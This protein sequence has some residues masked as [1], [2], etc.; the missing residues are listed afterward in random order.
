MTT[1]HRKTQLTILAVTIVAAFATIHCSGSTTQP[2]SG[3]AMAGVAL[4]ASSIAA[5]T[6]M[7]GTV[8]LTSAAA[9][10]G[11]S[12]SLSSSN[13]AVATVQTPIMVPAGASSAT[14]TVTA[15]AAGTANFTASFNGT[16]QSPMLT[17]TGASAL[18]SL[19]LSAPTI[20]GGNPVV[21]TVTLSNPAPSGGAVVALS[22][23][24]PVTVP[25]TVTV[26][27]GSTSATF[28][29]S[30]RTVG[31]TIPAT[32]TGSYGGRSASATV[33]VTAMVITTADAN[34]GVTG[35]ELSDT[36][37][38]INNG[39][40]LD[41]TFN[42]STST[43]PGTIIAWNWSYTVG[44]TTLTKTTTGPILSLPPASCSFVPATLP[45]GTTSFPLTVR[46]TIQD[47]LGNVSAPAVDDSAR[48]LPQGSCGFP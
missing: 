3:P 12:V 10:G 48:V 7:L 11:A 27:A 18:A 28:I 29:V 26:G 43:A 47:S 41:C 22:G 1:N 40:A 37:R 24:D 8:T 13:T 35:T 4:S 16:G 32:V 2:T 23:G 9:A 14:F 36:C 21:G 38:L 20:V 15:V 30:T 46:L 42:G 31:G 39:A 6:T 5:G 17:V 34:F 44:T 19:T 33:A 45:A 25:T